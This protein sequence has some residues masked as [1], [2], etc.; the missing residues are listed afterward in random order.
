MIALLSLL[1]HAE[2]LSRR[3][4]REKVEQVTW[5]MLF[6]DGNFDTLEHLGLKLISDLERLVDNGNFVLPVLVLLK[7]VRVI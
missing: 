5:S 7:L 3:S 6:L 1:E 4:Y 2:F